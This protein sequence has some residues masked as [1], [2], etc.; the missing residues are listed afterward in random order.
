MVQPVCLRCN[1]TSS[2]S[3]CLLCLSRVEVVSDPLLTRNLT[4]LA[5]PVGTEV[6][7]LTCRCR[8]YVYKLTVQGGSRTEVENNKLGRGMPF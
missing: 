8:T 3:V 5:C 4:T 1:T 6:A 2:A 7:C